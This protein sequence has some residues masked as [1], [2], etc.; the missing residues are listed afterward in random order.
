[1]KNKERLYDILNIVG[2]ACFGLG[3]AIG[4]AIV[5]TVKNSNLDWLPY[6][7]V[8]LGFAIDIALDIFVIYKKYKVSVNDET[9][10]EIKSTEELPHTLNIDTTNVCTEHT[11]KAIYYIPDLKVDPSTITAYVPADKVDL[12]NLKVT[13]SSNVIKKSAAKKT[14]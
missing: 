6:F 14:N 3:A 4:L 5:S 1:M 8:G 12:N 11:N 9:S 2:L 10:K 13:T 7:F